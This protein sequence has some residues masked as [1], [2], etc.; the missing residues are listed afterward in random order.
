MIVPGPLER[1]SLKLFGPFSGAARH[2]HLCLVDPVQLPK[3]L[4]SSVIARLTCPKKLTS[5]RISFRKTLALPKQRM[6]V[7]TADGMSGEDFPVS[8]SNHDRMGTA[9]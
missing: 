5:C 1:P 9:P 6:S 8:D 2:P 3:P 4:V 7:W